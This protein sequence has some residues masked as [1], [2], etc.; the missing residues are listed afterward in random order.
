MLLPGRHGPCHEEEA[1]RQREQDFEEARHHPEEGDAQ[2]LHAP[3]AGGA[4]GQ[5]TA[6]EGEAPRRP[7]GMF[8]GVGVPKRHK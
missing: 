5:R 2:G 3:P 4:V 6:E 8:G 1:G 7:G